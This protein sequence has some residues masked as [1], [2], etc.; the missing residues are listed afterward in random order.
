MH[1]GKREPS[2][3]KVFIGKGCKLFVILVESHFYELIDGTFSYQQLVL[4]LGERAE[5]EKTER[6]KTQPQERPRKRGAQYPVGGAVI[7]F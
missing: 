1:R 7:K 5:E 6:S 4:S 3:L 2:S